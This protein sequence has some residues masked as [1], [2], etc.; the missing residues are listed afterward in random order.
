M[1]DQSNG[2]EPG[3]DTPHE[4]ITATLIA[5]FARAGAAV[6]RLE[7]GGFVVCRWCYTRHCADLREL[8][9]FARQTGVTR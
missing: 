9:A 2:Q 1:Q 3:A 5:E 7:G 4:K 8:F 6:H